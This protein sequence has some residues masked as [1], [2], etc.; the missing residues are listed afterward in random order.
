M[1]KNR[2]IAIA[3]LVTLTLV[4][5]GVG[6]S[7]HSGR[8]DL[9]SASSGLTDAAALTAPGGQATQSASAEVSHARRHDD[10]ERDGRHSGDD[11]HEKK[12]ASRTSRSAANERGHDNDEDD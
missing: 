8:N 10:D 11:D 5:V 6:I 12:G 4:A 3:A 7:A 9:A 2:A 1:T